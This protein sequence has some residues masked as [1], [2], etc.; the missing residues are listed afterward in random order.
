MTAVDVLGRVDELTD[1]TGGSVDAVMG[2]ANGPYRKSRFC[3]SLAVA[4]PGTERQ[5]VMLTRREGGPGHAA[6]MGK[7]LPT[8]YIFRS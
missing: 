2:T 8:V 6:E 1:G 5:G 3:M 7:K 4:D